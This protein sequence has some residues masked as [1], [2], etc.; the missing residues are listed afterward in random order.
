M[1]KTILGRTGLKVSRTAFGALPIQRRDKAEAISILQKAYDNG[2]TLFDTARFYTD[3]EEKIGLALSHARDKIIIATKTMAKN[4]ENFAKDLEKSLSELKT[5]YI[6]IYQFH[7]AEQVY[8]PGDGLYE[9][10]EKARKEGKIR[11]IGITAHGLQVA[12]DAAMSGLYDTVQ[13]PLSMLSSEKEL[14]LIEVCRENNVGLLGMKGLGGGLIRHIPAAFTFMRRFSNLV[15]L[16]GIAHMHEL[17]EFLEL[18]ANPPAWDK[19][20]EEAVEE[21]K[22]QLGENFC[23]GCGYCLPCPA[24]IDLYNMG[25]IALTI[26][27]M[28][29]EMFTTPDWQKKVRQV[30]KCVECGACATRCPYKLNPQELIKEQS[31][32]YWQALKEQGVPVLA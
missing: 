29:F 12:M 21:E 20:M 17:D 18:S 23:R 2:I 15:P 1:E 9:Q 5:D 24:N 19:A 25:R 26:Q 8:R 30:E 11:F 14:K 27:R 4:P 10:M 32:K 31:A 28:P 3:S 13:F 16:W 7:F 6:D 22:A